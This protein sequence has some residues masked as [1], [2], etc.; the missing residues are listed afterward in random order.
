VNNGAVITAEMDSDGLEWRASNP[1]AQKH[2]QLS[3]ERDALLARPGLELVRAQVE[4][5]GDMIADSRKPGCNANPIQ[6][7]QRLP[8]AAICRAAFL[9][10][11]VVLSRAS[12]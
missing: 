1:S 4:V 7:E 10:P 3:R 11:V 8:A 9:E 2:R 12:R 6:G 5:V